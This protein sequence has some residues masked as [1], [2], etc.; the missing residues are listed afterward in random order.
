[1]KAGDFVLD[2]TLLEKFA[3]GV[4]VKGLPQQ[5]SYKEDTLF[6]M[7][8]NRGST[9]S[10]TGNQSLIFSHLDGDYRISYTKSSLEENQEKTLGGG[11]KRK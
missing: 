7:K 11:S 10:Q 9:I 8:Q 3:A 2:K 1:M 4:N 6:I 5:V